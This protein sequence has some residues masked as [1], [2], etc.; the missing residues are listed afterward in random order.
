MGSELKGNRDAAAEMFA[1]VAPAIYFGLEEGWRGKA[2]L[3]N[4]LQNFMKFS[5]FPPSDSRWF[6]KLESVHTVSPR[7]AELGRL[8]WQHLL[9]A[10]RFMYGNVYMLQET[11]ILSLNIL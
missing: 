3:S 4:A 1:L 11:D 2:G 7:N 10:A 6:E 5:T 9:Q 8:V